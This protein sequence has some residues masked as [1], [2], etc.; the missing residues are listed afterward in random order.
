[1]RPAVRRGSGRS[2]PARAPGLSGAGTEPDAGWSTVCRRAPGVRA[3][4]GGAERDV[5][6]V[7]L[8][9]RDGFHGPVHVRGDA[10]LTG[11]GRH[12]CPRPCAHPP[13]RYPCDVH[14]WAYADGPHRPDLREHADVLVGRD[15]LPVAQA[16][17]RVRELLVIRPGCLV[18]AVPSR[19]AGQLCVVG[20]RDGRGG[21]W[22]AAVE[23]EGG[24]SRGSVSVRTVAS[25]VHAWTVAGEPQAPLLFG[26][27]GPV[28]LP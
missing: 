23:G 1:M 10:L 26:S 19:R 24:A 13:G 4:L 17:R 28:R 7:V 27:P 12:R 3:A 5:S 15:P 8:R 20:V 11:T 16:H 2:G 14:L 25:V 6:V 18:A 22:S 9:H 21:V